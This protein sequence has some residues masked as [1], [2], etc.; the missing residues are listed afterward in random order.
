[1]RQPWRA[2]I[3]FW[4][5][6]SMKSI[7]VYTQSRAEE[8]KS[9]L[10]RRSRHSESVSR[11]P[12]F[13]KQSCM[14][15]EIPL[16]PPF[17]VRRRLPPCRRMAPHRAGGRLRS[18]GCHRHLRR[19]RRRSRELHP[20]GRRRFSTPLQVDPAGHAVFIEPK[21]AKGAMKTYTLS[22]GADLLAATAISASEG[23]R[24]PQV[25][26]AI[27]EHAHLQLS[28]CARPRSRRRPGSIPPRRPSAS[29]L[30]PQRSR[31]HRQ[32][33]PRSPLAPRRM[34]WLD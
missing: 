28:D 10:P 14:P 32:S 26:R 2:G 33:S 22:P 6:L 23:W 8:G 16:S 17:I 30:Q 5:V 12:L 29:H 20:Q 1:M 19:S 13:V 25:R 9:G 34:A 27:R 11:L 4:A 31:R 7:V 3:A 18:P 15:D 24:R 21:L